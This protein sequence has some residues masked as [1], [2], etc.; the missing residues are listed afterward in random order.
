MHILIISRVDPEALDALR[1][2]HEVS[3]LPN[4]GPEEL[5]GLIQ[6]CEVLIFRS[7]VE[8]SRDVLS[9]AHK[10][11][12]LI[13]AGSGTDNVDQQYATSRGIEFVRIPEP[14]A[15]AVSELAFGLMLGVARK[16]LWA[17]ATMRRGAWAKGE[18]DGALLYGKTL[19]ILGL[20]NIGNRV[21]QLGIAFGMKVIGCIDQPTP[22]AARAFASSG[23]TL[24]GLP[25]VV[26]RADFLSIHLPL[27][28]AT[29]GLLGAKLLS[30]M[31]PGAVLINLARGGV[32]DETVLCE[33]L[34]ENR[35]AGAGIDVHD[36]EKE[37]HVSPLAAF[38][39]VILTPH[40]GAQVGE[41]Q[42]RIGLRIVELVREH[43]GPAPATEPSI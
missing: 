6:D 20:G 34:R 21:A 13:R 12:V 16:L 1:R 35:L 27:T 14:S 22:S 42:R 36:V 29:R 26:S 38:P 40:I 4:P 37:G 7:G 8:L 10:L 9:C 43:A 41:C 28:E 15:W 3:Y 5:R 18:Y 23:V 17:D 32:V 31:K 25:E 2:E 30:T 11:R 24:L 19:G 39:N 33:L